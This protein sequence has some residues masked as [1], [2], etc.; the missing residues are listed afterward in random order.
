MRGLRSCVV[1]MFVVAAVP[2]GVTLA[3]A[4][5][6]RERAEVR[7]ESVHLSDLFVGLQSGQD[8][9]I[10]PAPAPGKRITV[11]PAQLTAIANEFGVD[12]T[13]SSAYMSTT[14]E[15]PA[16]TV[17]QSEILSVVE[18]ALLADGLP[19]SSNVALSAFVSPMLPT[20]Q[21]GAPVVQSLDYDPNSGH[22]SALI[23]FAAADTDPVSLRVVGIASEQVDVV[24]LYHALPA[25]SVLS[26]L[27]I[28]VIR[29]AKNMVRSNSVSDIS[30]AVGLSLKRGMAANVP[31]LQELLTRPVLVERGHQVVLKL[32]GAGLN[33]TAAGTALEAGAAGDRIRVVNPLS[34]AVLVGLIVGN[35]QVQIDPGT[36]PVI[37]PSGSVGAGSSQAVSYLA[38]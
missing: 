17:T 1:S 35:G 11:P 26:A 14:I 15:R 8:C 27:D 3:T 18:P 37:V 7:G 21:T 24:A 2:L 31:L 20:E 38:Q 19:P 28:H 6:L 13:P 9:E 12:W 30:E 4:A 25:G 5:S 34:R 22:F 33:L 16:R 32:E 36:A 10:G 23:A 29:M